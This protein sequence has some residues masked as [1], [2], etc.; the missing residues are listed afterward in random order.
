MAAKIADALF[1]L[2][3]R[4][5]HT[6]ELLSASLRKQVSSTILDIWDDN[7]PDLAESLLGVTS[8]LG[9]GRVLE[10]L[11]LKESSSF[12]PNVRR[13]VDEAIQEFGE[14]VNDPYSGMN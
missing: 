12:S 5:W 14:S 6:Y 8:R 13:I 7:D 3:E 4:Q 10:H 9:L 11:Q 1:E 2:S